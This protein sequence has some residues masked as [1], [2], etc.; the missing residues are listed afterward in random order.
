MG[1]IIVNSDTFW[2]G[3]ISKINLTNQNY[4]LIETSWFENNNITKKNIYNKNELAQIIEY[5]YIGNIIEEK[6]SN[7]QN[8]FLLKTSINIYLNQQLIKQI[9]KEKDNE[10]IEYFPY[11]YKVSNENKIH[12]FVKKLNESDSFLYSSY[13][14]NNANNLVPDSE[15]YYFKSGIL[16]YKV[17]NSF[18]EQNIPFKRIIYDGKG[19]IMKYKEL[20]Y[21]NQLKSKVICFDHLI[22]NDFSDFS[23]ETIEEEYIKEPKIVDWFSNYFE[24]LSEKDNLI[25][26][27]GDSS[28]NLYK[29]KVEMEI[30]KKVI[31][32]I[33]FNPLIDELEYIIEFKYNTDKSLNHYEM[34][35]YGDYQD[36]DSLILHREEEFFVQTIIPNY[37]HI[38]Q[39]YT[40]DFKDTVIKTKQDIYNYWSS[41]SMTYFN[42]TIT[43][44][45]DTVLIK[46]VFNGKLLNNISQIDEFNKQIFYFDSKGNIFKKEFY[47]RKENESFKFVRSEIYMIE[48]KD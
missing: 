19:N 38:T 1:Q 32:N 12:T 16:N 33:G 18:N 24:I 10:T 3:N 46:K 11:N 8:N 42:K 48:Y 31:Y 25:I 30:Y 5:K 36:N 47:E 20:E 43:N 9:V 21:L 44:N 2:Y 26:S 27:D 34:F 39:F 6:T 37:H 7:Y 28:N 22:I 35:K 15:V 23:K 40:F 4:D 17:Y 29:S 13:Y 45:E 41:D 14:Y